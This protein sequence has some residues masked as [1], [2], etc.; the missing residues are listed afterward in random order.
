MDCKNAIIKS[1]Y[2]VE[3]AINLL[4]EKAIQSAPKKSAESS[5]EG[6]VIFKIENDET[7]GKGIIFEIMCETDFAAKSN[8]FTEWSKML[9]DSAFELHKVLF[10]NSSFFLSQKFNLFFF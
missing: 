7:G 8:P 5:K 3:E 1:N 9:N 10:F 6:Q 4:G 2:N